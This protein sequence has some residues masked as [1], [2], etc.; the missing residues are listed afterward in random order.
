MF[1]VDFGVKTYWGTRRRVTLRERCRL[2]KINDLRL[3]F[4]R[5]LRIPLSFFGK[6]KRNAMAFSTASACLLC[7]QS[8]TDKSRLAGSGGPVRVSFVCFVSYVCNVCD[9]LYGS[10]RSKLPYSFRSFTGCCFSCPSFHSTRL[11]GIAG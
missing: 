1:P 6:A 4:Y 9:R 2:K 10:Q 3:P 5:A 7:A 11:S 8:L